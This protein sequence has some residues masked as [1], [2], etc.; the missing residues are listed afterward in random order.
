ML[1][2]A[3]QLHALRSR[4]PDEVMAAVEAHRMELESGESAP[5]VDLRTPEWEAFTAVGPPAP[6]NSDGPGPSPQEHL[7]ARNSHRIPAAAP[8]H[9]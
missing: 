8:P 5:D 9:A 4:D 7:V 2:Y 1:K 6:D 3:P